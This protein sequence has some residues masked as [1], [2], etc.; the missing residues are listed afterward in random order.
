MRFITR[1]KGIRIGNKRFS[2]H[3]PICLWYET[4]NDAGK[5]AKQLANLC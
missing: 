1:S 5:G 4:L 3:E 2:Y